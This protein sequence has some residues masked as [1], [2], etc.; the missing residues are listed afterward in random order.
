MAHEWKIRSMD[1]ADSRAAVAAAERAKTTAAVWVGQAI[2][3]RLAKEREPINGEVLGGV[4]GLPAEALIA[5]GATEALPRWLRTGAA[6]LLAARMGIPVPTTRERPPGR[7][8]GRLEPLSGDKGAMRPLKIP[9]AAP[10]GGGQVQA[11]G[12]GED[13]VAPA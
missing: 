13:G 2:R 8:Q 6:R 1:E 5:V 7:S 11:A 12:E 3:E 9:Q 4:E 10:T